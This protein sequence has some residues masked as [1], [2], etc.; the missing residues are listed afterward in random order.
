MP[1]TV[2]VGDKYYSGGVEVSA[3]AKK[4][5]SPKMSNTSMPKRKEIDLKKAWSDE[6][7]R[8]RKFSWS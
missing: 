1:K 6:V 7:E 3:P 5:E 4:I 8:K 2:K